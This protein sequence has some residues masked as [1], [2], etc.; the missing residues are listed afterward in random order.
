MKKVKVCSGPVC[1]NRG[2]K[3]LREK[4]ETELQNQTEF[5]NIDVE[6]CSCRGNCEFSPNIEVNGN[7]FG[8]VTEENILQT[9]KDA[10]EEKKLI[11]IDDFL[12]D[13]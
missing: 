8:N 6:Y 9:V 2:A 10:P 12:N 11:N 1:K 5:D 7:L 4:I 3:K 13:I